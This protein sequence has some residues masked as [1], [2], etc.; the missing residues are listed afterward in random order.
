MSLEIIQKV[1][2]PTNA[3]YINGVSAERRLSAAIL[4]NSYQGL[5]EKDDLGVNDKFVTEND[6]E[7]AAQ[8][9]VNRVLPVRI[10]PRE[11]GASRNGAS[12]SANKHYNQTQT[13]GIEILTVLDDPIIIPRARQDMIKVDLLAEQTEIFSKRL[14]TI[15]NG[16]TAASKI[17]SVYVTKAEGKAVNEKTITSTDIT[18]K[19]V[20]LRFEE[21]NDL[22]DEG[23]SDNGIDIFPEDTRV[24]VVKTGYRSILKGAGVL[25]LGGANY[26]YDIAKGS[27]IST[28]DTARKSEDGFIG[29]IDGVPCHV[30][31][32]ESLSHASE[33]LGFAAN[34]LKESQFI[35]YIASSYA[36]ARGVSTTKQTKIVDAQDG[37][38]IVLQP[39]VKF[40]TVSWYPK[41]NVIL[42]K[43]TWN[44]IADLETVFTGVTGIVYKLK[45]AGSRLYAN[46]RAADITIAADGVTVAAT[47]AALDDFN[48]D[49]LKKVAFVV[50]ASEIKTVSAFLDA[51]ASATYKGLITTLGTKE[52][53]TV[54]NNQYVTCLAIADDGT[55]VLVSKKAALGA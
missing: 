3:P 52:S 22:L 13:V 50:S 40:G 31:S 45:G 43:A 10:K 30:I 20:L 28:G 41:G 17:L 4:K 24:C 55:T 34:E 27:A 33:F 5:I 8:V 2:S 47:V 54:A 6:A 14:A 53:T 26:A 19:E 51:Y 18:N 32:N 7:Q 42:T 49:H 1:L 44:P 12:F 16:A 23:D 35:G 37:Q 15:L 25:Q 21:A 48:V 36:N 9:V 46:L 29:H 11:Q 39:Y 38:G